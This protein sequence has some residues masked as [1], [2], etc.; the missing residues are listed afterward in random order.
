MWSASGKG[1]HANS[2]LGLQR[3]PGGLRCLASTEAAVAATPVS[4]R[5]DRRRVHARTPW[6]PT[7]Y[8]DAEPTARRSSS[9]TTR[10]RARVLELA[11]SHVILIY[12]GAGVAVDWVDR[13]DPRLDDQA[14][15]KSIVTVSLYSEEMDDRSDVRDAVV[16][17]APPGGRT[18]KVLYRQLEE[19]G[20]GD[21][22]AAFLL[23][24]VIAHEIG[25][26]LLP[27]GAHAR[28][29]LMA[30]EMS[31]PIATS[32]PLF[33]TPAE[34]RLLRSALTSAADD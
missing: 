2:V 9:T 34:R 11:K 16:G 20:A 19:S 25:H 27:G 26:L 8:A 18:V 32:R 15:L 7:D 3:L 28:Y 30:P 4:K 21:P 23:G 13:E 1:R 10:C 14:F 17:K 5:Q 12:R 33:F 24:N 29:G 22:E 6:P 31:I